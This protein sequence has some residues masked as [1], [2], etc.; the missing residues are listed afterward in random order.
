MITRTTTTDDHDLCNKIASKAIAELDLPCEWVDSI[1]NA[2]NFGAVLIC[3]DNIEVVG[4]IVY[5]VTFHPDTKEKIAVERLLYVDPVHRGTRVAES[6]VNALEELARSEQCTA[7]H[8][9][10][11][12]HS[13]AHSRRLYERCGFKTNYTF[14]KEI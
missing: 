2:I 6:L 9:G 1:D 4:F 11:S 14:R 12:L 13:N 7:V 3:T 5:L 8:A 10:S